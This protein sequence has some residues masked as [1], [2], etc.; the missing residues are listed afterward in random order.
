MSASINKQKRKGR[1]LWLALGIGISLS[2]IFFGVKSLYDGYI[3][4]YPDTPQVTKK[5][6]ELSEDDKQ[7][8]V[9]IFH[10]PG[11]ADCLASRSTV[12]KAI[13]DNSKHVNYIV[14]NE[15]EQVAKNIIAQYGITKYPTVIALHGKQVV[16]S[17]TNWQGE[18]FKKSLMGD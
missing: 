14:I 16:S 17:S 1:W 7:K 9:L 5:I 4:G 2:I 6:A 10:K 11:C 13:Q 18:E 12:K 3:N 8:T 15:S